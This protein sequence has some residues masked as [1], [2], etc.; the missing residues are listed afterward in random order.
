MFSCFSCFSADKKIKKEELKRKKENSNNSINEKKYNSDKKESILDKDIS[1]NVVQI[2]K[3]KE[4]ENLNEKEKIKDKEKDNKLPPKHN[5]L[6]NKNVNISKFN[7]D[8]DI[9]H[10][11]ENKKLNNITNTNYFPESDNKNISNFDSIRKQVN[12]NSDI[13]TPRP[14]IPISKYDEINYFKSDLTQM[15]KETDI[16]I[17]NSDRYYIEEENI[18]FEKEIRNKTERE[19]KN[20]N[21]DK[22]LGSTKVK[23]NFS[24]N[25]EKVEDKEKSIEIGYNLNVKDIN[26]ENKNEDISNYNSIRSKANNNLYNENL[27]QKESAN[28]DKAEFNTNRSNNFTINDILIETNRKKQDSSANQFNSN[29]MNINQSSKEFNNNSNKD[30]LEIQ[31]EVKNK[32]IKS[33]DIEPDQTNAIDLSINSK[34]NF[35]RISI[36]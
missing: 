12:N 33:D 26:L 28:R 6:K 21:D 3:T 15:N 11:N 20:K 35:I 32:I 34:Y 5:N 23:L 1:D 4:D 9:S 27:K 31:N 8:K 22:R 10:E 36:K 16:K 25:L 24:S 17:N 13:N 14:L 2:D 18:I 30:F 29:T 7:E 19:R